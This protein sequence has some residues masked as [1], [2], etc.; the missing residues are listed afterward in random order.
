MCHACA[1]RWTQM[2]KGM[3][4]QQE[5]NKYLL[6]DSGYRQMKANTELDWLETQG[7]KTTTP[8]TGIH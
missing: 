4:R 1:G 7:A 8:N 2:Q 6:P 5:E 3:G